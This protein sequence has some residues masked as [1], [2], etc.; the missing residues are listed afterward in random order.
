MCWSQFKDRCCK[1]VHWEVGVVNFI[2]VFNMFIAVIYFF[3]LLLAPSPLS[4]ANYRFN[5]HPWPS[6]CNFV[7]SSGSIRRNLSASQ[8]REDFVNLGTVNCLCFV[9]FRNLFTIMFQSLMCVPLFW[10]YIN[11]CYMIGLLVHYC[12]R[13][14]YYRCKLWKES[15]GFCWSEKRSSAWY[16][17]Y[18]IV[19]S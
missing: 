18:H 15:F 14:G 3:S 19:I 17:F 7:F 6:I 13:Q 9:N 2:S 8:V 11:A 10:C 4:P 5:Q 12:L 1:I 16:E